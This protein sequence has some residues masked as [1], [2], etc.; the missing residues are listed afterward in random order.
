LEYYEQLLVTLTTSRILRRFQAWR[1][2]G[3]GATWDTMIFLK[4]IE[5]MGQANP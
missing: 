4:D 2:C 5:L 1:C 3:N